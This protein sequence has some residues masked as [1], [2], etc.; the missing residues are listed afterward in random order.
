MGINPARL[1]EHA[2]SGEAQV[3]KLANQAEADGKR[4][5]VQAF[6]SGRAYNLYTF[7][8]NFKPDSIR[9]FFAGEGTFWTDLTRFEELGAAKLLKPE[10]AAERG[11]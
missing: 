8:E 9:L 2:N 6:G 4:M 10:P 11:R 3:E 7:A 5:F 1:I